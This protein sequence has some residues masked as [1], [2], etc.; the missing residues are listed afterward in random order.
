MKKAEVNMVVSNSVLALDLYN[1]IFELEY[2]E[3]TNLKLGNNEAFFSINGL[4]FHMY[5][6]NLE[7]GLVA[8]FVNEESSCWF[9]ITV[10]NIEDIFNKANKYHCKITMPITYI[11]THKVYNGMFKDH[12]GYS[13]LIHQASK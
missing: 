5:D 4:H 12:F 7:Y 3:K 1:R 10:D 8:P 6:E 2:Y 13:W 11:E 9:N